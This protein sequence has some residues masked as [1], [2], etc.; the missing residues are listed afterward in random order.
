[1]EGVAGRGSGADDGA[2]PLWGRSDVADL[3]R[4]PFVD[5]AAFPISCPAVK[6]PRKSL[7]GER[8]RS[9]GDVDAPDK[10]LGRW[11]DD[12]ALGRALS[13]DKRESEH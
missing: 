11:R 8:I 4:R 6:L 9:A 3:G 13:A 1:M 12:G 10:L 5:A 7:H 2:G